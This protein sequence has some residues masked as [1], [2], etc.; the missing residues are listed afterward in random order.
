MGTRS[1]RLDDEAEQA[2][3]DIMAR[4]TLSI[5]DAIKQGLMSY[6]EIA[7]KTSIRKPSDFFETFD[8]GEGGYSVES[9]RNSKETIRNN[10]RN[11]LGQKRQ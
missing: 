10:M 11:K 1:V 8:L 6:R 3:E 4:T 7:L 2:L 5:S 9:A